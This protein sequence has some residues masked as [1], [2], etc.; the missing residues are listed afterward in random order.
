MTIAVDI[1]NDKQI[2]HRFTSV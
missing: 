2:F 1:L